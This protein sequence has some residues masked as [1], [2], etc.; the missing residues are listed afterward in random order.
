MTVPFKWNIIIRYVLSFNRCSVGR[1]GRQK[2]LSRKAHFTAHIF[3]LNTET[4]QIKS[5][6]DNVCITRHSQFLKLLHIFFVCLTEYCSTLFYIP[7]RRASTSLHH[8]AVYSFTCIIAIHLKTLLR[9][10]CGW[11]RSNIQSGTKYVCFF[12][13]IHITKNV[14]S[15]TMSEWKPT[16]PTYFYLQSQLF[17]SPFS[18]IFIIT[19]DHSSPSPT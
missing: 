7:N 3:C 8:S 14:I 2:N 10:R 19:Y 5:E 16:H 6:V 13:F 4:G 17:H 11:P 18:L 12:N 9:N 15:N 1:T